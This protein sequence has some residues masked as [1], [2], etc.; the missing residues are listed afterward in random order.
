MSHTGLTPLTTLDGGSLLVCR[1]C[2]ALQTVPPYSVGSALAC[3]RCGAL[4][5]RR[6]AK[7][8]DRVLPLTLAALVLFLLANTTPV[9]AIEVAGNRSSTSLLGTVV[10]LYHQGAVGVAVI[11]FLTGFVAPAADLLALLYALLALAARRSFRALPG[12]VRLLVALRPW[13]MV[14]IFMLGALVSLVKLAGL[15]RVIPGV[16]LWSL[17]G[18]I[19]LTAAAHSEFDITAYWQRVR[20]IR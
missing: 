4:L 15:A 8:L 1:E 13:S 18:V 2:D 16:G 11:V 17:F 19:I 5:G 10:E 20:T 12:A 3:A 7:T 14:E 6:R 9:V